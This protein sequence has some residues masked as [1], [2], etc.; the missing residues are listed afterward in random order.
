[1]KKRTS[2][3]ERVMRAVR[4][5]AWFVAGVA[6][7]AGA[8]VLA[9]DGADT[10]TAVQAVTVAA[11]AGCMAAALGREDISDALFDEDV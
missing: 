11:G 10:W 2:R 1:M 3:Q 6:A 7:M 9:M 4:A 5:T 8:A